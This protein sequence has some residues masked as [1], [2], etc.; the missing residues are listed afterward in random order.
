MNAAGKKAVLQSAETT[1][2]EKTPAVDYA[3]EGKQSAK[4]I[5]LPDL[6]Y[7]PARPRVFQPRIGLIACGGITNH[8]LKAY[9]QAGYTVV[10][11]ADPRTELA[12]KRKEEFQLHGATIHSDAAE[13][14]A[15]PDINVVDIATHPAERAS[16]I[17]AAIHAGK[18]VLSQKPFVV[19]L[20]VGTRL[21]A[22]ADAAGVRLAVNQNGRWSPH[23][24]WMRQAIA[25]GL[26]GQ[27]STADAMVIWDHRWVKGTA[28]EHIPHLL[29]YDFAIHWFDML[30]C[31][32]GGRD[33]RDVTA[34]L[35]DAPGQSVRPPLLASVIVRFD[36]GQASL[37]FR[38]ATGYGQVDQT[39]IT[40][41]HGMLRSEGKDINEQHVTLWNESGEGSPVLSGRW[42]S[43][44]FDGTM[45]ELL[46]AIEEGRE[47]NNSGRDN[48]G[49]VAL[50]LAA[51]ASAEVG[52][53]VPVGEVRRVR[54]EWLRYST[55]EGGAK[56]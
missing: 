41:T 54:P 2:Q 39:V 53:A 25:A 48:L 38:G 45:S 20:E 36:E 40:G 35:A 42:F 28:F 34:I 9:A 24:S 1:P 37:Q 29:L 5:S 8:H 46:V 4:R 12:E 18:H 19:D 14:L 26:I 11:L 56:G 3:L 10:A 16:L 13:L 52:R 7:L 32:F 44:G 21:C 30:R 22:A 43:D 15:R 47:P 55:P 33:A 23:V 27:V 6:P 17:E 31:Y 50:A 51:M 49:T